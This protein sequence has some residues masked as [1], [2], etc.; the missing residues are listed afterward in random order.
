[1]CG[2]RRCGSCRP[3]FLGLNQVFRALTG[4]AT[5]TRSAV[6][7]VCDRPVLLSST[8]GIVMHAPMLR[9]TDGVRRT[10]LQKL[11]YRRAPLEGRS[12]M[13]IEE[14]GFGQGRLLSALG[15][16]QTLTDAQVVSVNRTESGAGAPRSKNFS[17]NPSQQRRRE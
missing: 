5:L 16:Y 17:S 1:M 11:W 14:Q 13:C 8:C 15:L 2:P 9:E 3:G 12:K 4:A 10:P 6:A 7:A